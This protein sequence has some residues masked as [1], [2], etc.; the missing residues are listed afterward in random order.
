MS[1]KK[2][3]KFWF[4]ISFTIIIVL[5]AFN[6]ILDPYGI[7][8]S[9]YFSFDKIAQTRKIKLVKAIQVKKIKPASIALGTSRAEIGYDP[10]HNY[11]LKPSYN[12]ATGGGT[13]YENMVY[14]KYALKQGNLKQVLLV[15]DYRMFTSP[16]QKNIQEFETYFKENI[17]YT[18]LLSI[19]AIKDALLTIKGGNRKEEVSLDNGQEDPSNGKK[20]NTKQGELFESIKLSEKTYYKRYKT[21]YRYRDTNKKSFPDFEEIVLL[22]YKNNIQLDIIFGPSH[23]RQWEALNYY[24]T[25]NKWLKWKKD[26]ILSVNKIA[27]EQ[28][29]KQFRIMDFSVYHKLTSEKIPKKKNTQMKYYWESNHYKNELGLIVLNR[30]IKK[31]KYKNFGIELSLDNID[32]HLEEQKINRHKFID[33]DKYQLEVFGKIK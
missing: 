19:D 5:S 14:F 7:Y 3:I 10:T 18:L 22:S 28:N 27:N 33:I 4:I 15:A 8:Q 16:K 25:Y 31:S 17:K 23:I 26:I 12:L 32:K 29:K 20:Q 11:F 9:K 30:L 1:S 24:L 6:Y 21:S 2:W 13:M